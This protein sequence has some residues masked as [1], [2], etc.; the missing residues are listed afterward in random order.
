M[1]MNICSFIVDRARPFLF[2]L[3]GYTNDYINASYIVVSLCFVIYKLQLYT[4]FLGQ[5]E[6]HSDLMSWPL[7]CVRVRV[8]VRCQLFFKH[9]LKNY[10]T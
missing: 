4:I 9:L 6:I 3:E 7:V 1:S 8:C 2:R 5:N 10:D